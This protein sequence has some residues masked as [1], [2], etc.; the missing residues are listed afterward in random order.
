MK[1]FF[2]LLLTTFLLIGC[3][4]D[5]DTIYDFIGTW[6]GTYEGSDKGV[7]NMVVA[8]DGKVTGTMHSDQNNENYNI[9][10]HVSDTGELNAS[11]GLPTDGEFR[12]NLTREKT[13]SGSWRNS[14]PTPERTGTWSGEKN[15]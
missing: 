13:G 14:V 8:S 4:S 12:G 3:N 11:I 5:E 1:K 9:S 2:L 6:S 10:G 15:K 7:W